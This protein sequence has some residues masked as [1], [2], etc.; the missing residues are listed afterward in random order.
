MD[1]TYRSKASWKKAKRVKEKCSRVASNNVIVLVDDFSLEADGIGVD[2]EI[3]ARR[4][5]CVGVHHPKYMLLF[6][7]YG[8][9]VITVSTSNLTSPSEV[10]AKKVSFGA[11]NVIV[12]SRPSWVRYPTNNWAI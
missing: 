10:D 1:P 4:K 3:V 12:I 2:P 5:S 6:G 8:S 7:R 11:S 9:V